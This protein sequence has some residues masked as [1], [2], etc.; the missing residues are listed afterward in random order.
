M[1][2]PDRGATMVEAALVLPILI[3]LLLAIIEVGGTLKSYSGAAS[4]VR[5]GSRAASVA[6][7]DRM[8]DRQILEQMA[9]LAG[10]LDAGEIELVVIWHAEGPGDPVPPDCLPPDTSSPN[11]ASVGDAGSVPDGMGACNAYIQPGD[12][13]GAFAMAQGTAP[14]PE[15][16][17]FGCVGPTDPEAL[18]LLDCHWPATSRQV[19]TSPRGSLD[20][21]STDFV[22]VYMRVRHASYTG[23]LGAG[24]T[25]TDR[26]ISLIEPQGYELS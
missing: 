23:V 17:Y 10:S 26:S 20:P 8:A 3:F 5:S 19:L 18:H 14:E 9:S 21:R 24:I 4:S 7:A 11:Q 2:A 1:T 25:I 6:G 13:G 15:E 16:H 12:E 22:G